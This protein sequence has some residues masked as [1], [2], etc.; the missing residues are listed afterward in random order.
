[1]NVT[2]IPYQLQFK[3]PFHIAHGK[4]DF[5]QVVYIKLQHN[6]T[7]GW[8]EVALPPYL[9]ETTES[10]CD[11][12]NNFSIAAIH[13]Y[14]D[15]FSVIN[16]LHNLPNN[17]ASKAGIEMALLDWYGKN[18][19]TSVYDLLDIPFKNKIKTAFTIPIC[20]ANDFIENTAN[21]NNFSFLKIKMGG[22]FDEEIFPLLKTISQP[23]A[24]DANQ[25]WRNKEDALNYIIK[26]HEVGALFIEQPLPV[27]FIEEQLWLKENSPLPIYADES[28]QTIEDLELTAK[29][30]DGINI[31]LVKCGGITKALAIIKEAKKIPLKILIGC[32]S[33]S[34]CAV[35][36]AAH[37][38]AFADYID[39]DGPFLI[40]NNPFNTFQLEDGNIIFSKQ[41]GLGI[42]TNEL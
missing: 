14:E 36:A 15:L 5:T 1:M 30:F 32:M 35:T 19:K 2:A 10:V 33:E 3:K 39:L 38:T 7:I 24:V 9:K 11:F 21:A 13:L 29:L 34:S 42:S 12:V 28:F 40:A 26:L 31:K 8:G 18:F 20:N 41:N 22:A 25:G 37:L 6:N 17:Y 23:F 4:R 16:S 27:S